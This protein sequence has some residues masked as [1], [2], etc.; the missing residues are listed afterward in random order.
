MQLPGTPIK[1]L[2]GCSIEPIEIKNTPIMCILG[3]LLTEAGK[4]IK[5]EMIEQ[6]R[7]KYDII[8]VNQEPPGKFFEYPALSFAQQFSIITG[9]PV[10][11]VHTKGAANPKNVYNQTKVRWLWYNEF[12]SRYN[13]YNTYV[14]KHI[15][16]VVC[17]FSGGSQYT[18][19]NGFIATPSAWKHVHLRQTFD[20][21]Y[22]EYIFQGTPVKIHGRIMNNVTLYPSKEAS[23]M[24]EYINNL[25]AT[26]S[27]H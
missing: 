21:Y 16:D 8:A 15:N 14:S 5:A 19:M 1:T 9:K 20:R 13:D 7:K 4:S 18:W 23:T 27:T 26:Q 12:I 2:P 3:C 10:L 6:F 25:A 11:Y 24:I 22:Y 17:P